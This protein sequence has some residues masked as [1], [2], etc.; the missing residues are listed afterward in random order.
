MEEEEV[1]LDTSIRGR[2]VALVNKMK[3]QPQKAEEKP[4]EKEQDIPCKNNLQLNAT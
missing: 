4:T 1:D 2:L 3:G